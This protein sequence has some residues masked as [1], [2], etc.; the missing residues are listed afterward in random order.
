MKSTSA[1]TSFIFLVSLF[2]TSHVASDLTDSDVNY[3]CS[4]REKTFTVRLYGNTKTN[5]GVVIPSRG[6]ERE[7]VFYIDDEFGYRWVYDENNSKGGSSEFIVD[8]DRE[9]GYYVFNDDGNFTFP[10]FNLSCSVTKQ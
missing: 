3:K 9:G 2:F 10:E 6:A 7:V 1:L 4:N 8:I 5:T